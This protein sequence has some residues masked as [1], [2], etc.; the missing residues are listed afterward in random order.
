M[1]V[2]VGD[3]VVLSGMDAID[4]DAPPADRAEAYLAGYAVHIARIGITDESFAQR[5]GVP[6]PIRIAR[7]NSH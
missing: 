4:R 6:V 7:V 1:P 2:R 5:Y 3:I